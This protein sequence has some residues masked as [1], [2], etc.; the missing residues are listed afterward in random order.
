MEEFFA[1]EFE[2]E[3]LK[4]EN[5][6]LLDVRTPQEFEEGHLEN[7]TLI[8][9]MDPEFS[10]KLN[11]LDKAKNYYVYCRSGQ[12]SAAACHAM[13]QLGFK[14]RLVNLAGGILAWNG[15]IIK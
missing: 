14:G 2:N 5:S 1:G 3:M 13:K 9:V 6:F 7:A 8:N 15:P 11:E 12:R 10:S 4:D